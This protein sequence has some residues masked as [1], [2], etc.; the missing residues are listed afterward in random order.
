MLRLRSF[1]LLFFAAGALVAAPAHATD[2]TGTTAYVGYLW[3]SISSVYAYYG[4]GT[5]TASGL[6]TSIFSGGSVVDVYPTSLTL[7]FP[8]YDW[9]FSTSSKTFDGIGIYDPSVTFTSASLSTANFDFSNDV[10]VTYNG[11]Y[12]Y[13]NFPNP[14]FGDGTP[15]TNGGSLPEG[16]S[17]TVDFTSMS[18]AST[19]EPSTFALL[20]TG[21]LGV[22][23]SARRRFRCS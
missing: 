21:I 7:S 19:P 8:A 1:L 14:P 4:D 3:P 9:G 16:A 18:V 10:E 5:V 23:G 15:G 22:V 11:S 2:L 20:G 17:L 13:I 6:N 12:L